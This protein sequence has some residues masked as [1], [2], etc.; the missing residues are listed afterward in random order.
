MQEREGERKREREKKQFVDNHYYKGLL[1]VH[2]ACAAATRP[3]TTL[4]LETTKVAAAE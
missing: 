1:Y 4:Q 2:L 3:W